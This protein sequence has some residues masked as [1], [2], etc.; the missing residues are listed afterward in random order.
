MLK[1]NYNNK[2]SCD[3][4]KKYKNCC[5]NKNHNYITINNETNR[6][7]RC[8]CNSG[9]KYKN[10]CL[11][12]TN[13]NKSKETENY[14]KGQE[15]YSENL[16]IFADYLEDEYKNHEVINISDYLNIDNYRDF[17]IKNY[18]NKLIMIA[19]KNNNNSSVFATR[20]CG[21]IIIMYKGSYRTFNQCDMMNVLDSIDKMIQIRLAGEEDK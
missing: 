19:E 17:Q 10:C 8:A 7:E 2:C 16:R 13:Q 12:K 4:G 5:I 1:V 18:T 14:T 21:D 3:S 20:G 9:K 15:S 6:N 11:N